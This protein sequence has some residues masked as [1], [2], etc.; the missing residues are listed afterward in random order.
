MATC[1]PHELVEAGKCFACLTPQQAQLVTLALLCDILQ[2]NDPMATCDVHELMQDAK[3]FVGLPLNAA[4]AIEIQLLC[5]ILHSGGTG[6]TCL[7][8]GVGAPV[9]PASCDCS[10]YYS[11]PPNAGVWVWDSVTDAW[12]CVINPG[13]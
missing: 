3:C 5:E 11:L 2:A 4:K 1:S 12:E 9:A 10:I 8:C 7:L 13:V 6:A